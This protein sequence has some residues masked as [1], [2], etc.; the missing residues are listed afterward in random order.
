VPRTAWRTRLAKVTTTEAYVI[1]RVVRFTADLPACLVS[2]EK[3]QTFVPAGPAG[4]GAYMTAGK[5][6]F[7]SRGTVKR[8]RVNLLE[9]G[10][11]NNMAA[12][13]DC[14]FNFHSSPDVTGLVCFT[15][16]NTVLFVPA[17]KLYVVEKDMA[18]ST[19]FPTRF[20]QA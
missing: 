6:L 14:L 19:V 8:F 18:R 13:R 4:P 12:G 3:V 17:G 16:T 20:G 1:A 5:K 7:A 9:A 11:S 2:L 10:R 15:I